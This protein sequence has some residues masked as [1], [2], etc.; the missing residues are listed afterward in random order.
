MRRLDVRFR[1]QTRKHLLA[2]RLTGFDP[3]QTCRTIFATAP[4]GGD[5]RP[6]GREAI[7]PR[8]GGPALIARPSTALA[9]VKTTF[10]G[11]TV[12][13]SYQSVFCN[14]SGGEAGVPQTPAEVRGRPA[15]SC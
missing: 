5:R 2:M 12:R 3:L 9:Q 11:I 1:A 10:D 7:E 15:P 4:K 13:H 14:T 6:A 8:R